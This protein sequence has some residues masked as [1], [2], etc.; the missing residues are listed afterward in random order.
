MTIKKWLP[1]LASLLIANACISQG[2]NLVTGH[3]SAASELQALL[4]EAVVEGIPGISA[5]IATRDGVVW[6]GAAGRADLK[7]GAP[8]RPDML[9]GIG[10]IT[11][12]FI[13]VLIL[14]LAEEGKL[15][16][17]ATAASLLG[18]A[19]EG[20]PNANKATIAHLLNHTSGIPSWEDDPA[21]I[22]DGRG[23]QLEV[24]RIWDKTATLPYIQGHAPLAAPGAE[25]SYANTNFTLLGMIIEKVTGKDVVD[26]IQRRILTPIGLKDVYLEGFEPVP[27]GRLPHRYHWATPAFRQNAGLN[28]AFPEVR[29][30]LIDASRSN[31]SGEWTAGGMLATAHD[32]ALYAAAL[33]D[34]RYLTSQSMDFMTEWFPVGEGVQVGHNLYLIEYPDGPS[35]IGH[36]GDVLGFTGSMYWIEGIDAVVTVLCNVGAMHAG[37]VPGKAPS[38]A[39]SSAFIKLAMRVAASM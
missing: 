5:A 21:W 27:D 3:Q 9:F 37:G 30:G 24:N 34:G 7:A 19:V 36:N 6:R 23:D 1:S 29:P 28:S 16:L 14:Q 18:S 13:A 2:A 12:T 20:I 32:L 11:K 31:L 10:S 38:V 33:R 25:F 26:E 17:N 39:Q 8:V 22:R 35:I 4:D 15:D